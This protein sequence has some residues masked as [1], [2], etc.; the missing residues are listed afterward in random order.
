[1]SAEEQRSWYKEMGVQ[2]SRPWD[3]KPFSFLST[4]GVLDQYLPPE[5]DGKLSPLNTAVRNFT[6]LFNYSEWIVCH[7]SEM[8]WLQGA[9]QKMEWLQ[10]KTKSWKDLRDIRKYEDDFDLYPDFVEKAQDIYIKAHEAL[11]A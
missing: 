7:F 4:A 2:P 1:M 5:G 3:E 6:L 8:I 9:K 10:K 11:A